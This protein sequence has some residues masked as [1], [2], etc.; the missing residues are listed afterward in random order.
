MEFDDAPARTA[1]MLTNLRAA[2]NQIA[3]TLGEIMVGVVE[4]THLMQPPP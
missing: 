2:Q 1:E 4:L 3:A